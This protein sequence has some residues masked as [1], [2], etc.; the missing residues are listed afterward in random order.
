MCDEASLLL[1]K[2]LVLIRGSS[3]LLMETNQKCQYYTL[4]QE[5]SLRDIPRCY[6]LGDLTQGKAGP[7]LLR[8]AMFGFVLR[9]LSEFPN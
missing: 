2:H 3:F 5:A 6:R 7:A 1:D 8:E 9:D 4:S